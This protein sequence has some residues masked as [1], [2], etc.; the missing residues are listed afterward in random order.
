MAADLRLLRLL[1]LASPA[2]PVGAFHFSQGLEY[3]IEAGWVR[4]EASALEWIGGL[5]NGSLG[6]LDLPVLARLL[7]AY[8]SQR[9]DEA[10][11][12]N[13]LLTAARETAELRA[14]DRHMGS[15]LV[16]ILR[17]IDAAVLE[18]IPEQPGYAAVFAAACACWSV[19]P[20]ECLQAYAWA[21]T[22][23]QVLAAV[24]L[25]PLGQSAGQRILHVL[26][27]RLAAIST[28]ALALRDEDIGY[29]AVMQS[30]ASARHETQYTRLFRS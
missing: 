20:E 18:C 30:V 14:E 13:A 16:K 12:W 4:D 22:E 9:R 28:R 10:M 17:E 6:K 23:N 5:A 21:W 2:L 8:G 7:Q 27:P 25:V 15:A 29:C 24:K 11:R 3:A 19:T 26:I 1:H